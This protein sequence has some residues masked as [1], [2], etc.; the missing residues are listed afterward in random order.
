MNC[1][2][3]WVDFPGKKVGVLVGF[4][5][6]W[7]P[8]LGAKGQADIGKGSLGMFLASKQK[9]KRRVGD[10]EILVRVVAIRGARDRE[11][12]GGS[13]RDKGER[14]PGCPE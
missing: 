6:Q 10:D 11:A 3:P 12:G 2:L 7:A 1:C 9:V 4:V 13:P 8:E 5:L 14:R